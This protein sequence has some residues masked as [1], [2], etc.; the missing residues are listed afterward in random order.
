MEEKKMMGGSK[1]MGSSMMMGQKYAGFW[2]R[3]LAYLID[4]IIL[5]VVGRILFGSQVTQYDTSGSGVSFNVSY[6]GWRV[7]IPIGYV[8]I[9]WITLSATPGKMICKLKICPINI[10]MQQRI[11]NKK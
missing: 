8:L 4:S 5:G 2:I 3:F 9:F 6:T 10:P 11:K 1:P 7:I